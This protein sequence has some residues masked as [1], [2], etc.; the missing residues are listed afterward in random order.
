MSAILAASVNG[1]VLSAVV[2]AAVW[3]VMRML[4]RYFLNAAT[5]YVVWWAA[6]AIT[7]SL[8][9][10]YR[11]IH[12]PL[13]PFSR[14]V[15]SKGEP[16]H[17]ERSEPAMN[18]PISL[19]SFS[20]SAAAR[21]WS[22]RIVAA[23]ALISALLLIRLIA[24]YCLLRRKQARANPAPPSLT[25]RV[26]QWLALCGSRRLHVRLALSNE[27]AIPMVAGLRR[28]SIL[29]PA[30]LLVALSDRELDQIG[31]HEA[32]HVAR[33]D[34]YALMVQRVVEAILVLH[35]VVRWI[36]KQIDLEREIACDDFV[37]HAT[38]NPSSYAECLI[39]IVE[40]TGGAAPSPSRPLRRGIVRTCS[41]ASTGCSTARDP[42][43]HGP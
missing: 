13:R 22:E 4:P 34:A 25:A 42:P 2:T 38:R 32:A 14:P 12:V 21:R 36:T 24:S 8:P 37:V 10:L 1:A 20:V 43:A 40:L 41:C 28:Q 5:R 29:I 26:E 16:A 31:L 35:P 15:P 3:L 23:W 7:I 11:P 30:R 39:R 6:L 27:I 19:P 17:S 33:G 9:L 18:T